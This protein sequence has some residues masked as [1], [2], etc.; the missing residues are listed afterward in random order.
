MAW[1]LVG[2]ADTK[3]TV[4]FLKAANELGVQV[5]FV[6]VENCKAEGLAGCTIKLDPPVYGSGELGRLPELTGRYINLLK[7]L[8][9]TEGLRFLNHPND[10]LTCLDKKQCKQRLMQAGIPTTP[11]LADN[12]T[13]FDQLLDTMRSKEVYRVFIKP[14]LGSGAAGIIALHAHPKDDKM[15]MYT[16]AYSASKTLV[17]T[18]RIIHTANAET[19]KRTV[20]Q[21]LQQAT[22]VERWIP[23]ATHNGHCYD[24][25]VLWQFGKVAFT[26]ARMSQSP[27]TNLH[28]NNMALKFGDLNLSAETIQKV[29]EVCRKTMLLFPKL[30]YAGIDVLLVNGS[31]EPMVIEVN[32]QGDLIY[33]DIYAENSIYKQQLQ[34]G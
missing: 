19:I 13:G 12:L 24:L 10:I 9:A 27:I 8:A 18:K 5:R 17:N 33:Q 14:N 2:N 1:T 20:N 29:E 3:R 15:T 25:R 34:E 16:S 23:K 32:G 6:E 31:L 11:L 4:Y 28:L 22:V 7:R 30:S 26:V 21:L